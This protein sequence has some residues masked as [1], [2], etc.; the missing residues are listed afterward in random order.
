MASVY[1]SDAQGLK[2][3]DC[4][5]TAGISARWERW[6]RAFELFA[7][8]KGVKNIDQKKAL[9]LHT[10]GLNVQDI[11]LTLTEEEGSDSYQK[12]KATL[13]KYFKPQANVP[14]E[15]LCFRE[16]SQLANE[17]VEQFITTLRQK[18]QTCEFEEAPTVD[19]QNSDQVTSKWLSHELR[20]KL[21]QKGRNFTLPQLREIANS[22]EESEKQARSIEGGSGEVRS[23]VNSVSGKTN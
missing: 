13:N 11:D 20:R 2:P 4:S 15:R 1:L 6:L 7:T 9:L 21:F 23:E 14:Y 3:F 8:G 12:A 5:E 19:E 17:T 10:A 18:A 16:T 22:I